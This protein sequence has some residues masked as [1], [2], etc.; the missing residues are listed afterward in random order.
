M[1]PRK[2]RGGFRKQLSKGL[3]AHSLPSRECTIKAT[4]LPKTTNKQCGGIGK[5]QSKGLRRRSFLLESYTSM[6]KVTFPLI[7]EKPLAS[8]QLQ[9]NRATQRQSHFLHAISIRAV[10]LFSPLRHRLNALFVVVVLM[11]V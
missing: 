9:L 7:D 8:S 6:V 1:P 10:V 5:R 4:V 2:Q 3:P 11:A